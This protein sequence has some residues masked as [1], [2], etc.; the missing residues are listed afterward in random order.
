LNFTSSK[1][2]SK[3]SFHFLKTNSENIFRFEVAL[4]VYFI[5]MNISFKYHFK[6]TEEFPDE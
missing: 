1:Q 3:L 2:P 4:S 6:Y 5:F